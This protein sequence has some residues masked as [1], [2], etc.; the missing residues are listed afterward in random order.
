V[1]ATCATKRVWAGHTFCAHLPLAL[2]IALVANDDDREVVPVLDAQ[3][4]LLKCDHL[5][6]ALPGCDAVDEEEAF[7]SS[8]VLLAHCGVLF[9]TGRVEDVEERNLIVDDALLTVR[10]CM[11]FSC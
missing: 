7:A 2:Q 10:I 1:A 6:E 5:L 9:L 3:Y 8:H 11:S 4:L